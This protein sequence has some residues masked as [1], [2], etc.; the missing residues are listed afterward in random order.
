[1]M[2]KVVLLFAASLLLVLMV[3]IPVAGMEEVSLDVVV[4][5][6]GTIHGGG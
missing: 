5:V 1:M 4:Q 2:R 6:N 3:S